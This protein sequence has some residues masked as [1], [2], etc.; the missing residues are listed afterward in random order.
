MT[1]G[2]VPGDLDSATK[3]FA[4]QKVE[5]EKEKAAWEIAHAKVDTLIRAVKDLKIKANKLASQIPILQEKVKHL[6]NKVIDGL[7]EIRA[8]ELDLEHT[9]KANNDY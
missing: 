3:A 6:D 7:N 1:L 9:I 5:M 2:I 8:M 4:D